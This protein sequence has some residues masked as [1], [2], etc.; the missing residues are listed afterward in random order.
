LVELLF[1]DKIKG[2]LLEIE[3]AFLCAKESIEM[4]PLERGLKKL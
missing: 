1:L 4:E 2:M 3:E